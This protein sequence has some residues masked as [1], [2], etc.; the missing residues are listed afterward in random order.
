MTI[1]KE[2][3][4]RDG[5]V[6]LASAYNQGLAKIAIRKKPTKFCQMIGGLSIPAA[7]VAGFL[8]SCSRRILTHCVG[9]AIS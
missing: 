8:F 1:L 2:P 6:E 3:G 9:A 5:F 4:G 7:A